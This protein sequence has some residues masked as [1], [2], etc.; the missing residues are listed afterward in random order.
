MVL[1]V[2]ELL[3]YKLEF[4]PVF[5]YWKIF[6]IR[7]SYFLLYKII[8]FIYEIY[9]VYTIIL[10]IKFIQVLQVGCTYIL[11]ILADLLQSQNGSA[12]M[13]QIVSLSRNLLPFILYAT[14]QR[15]TE[16]SSSAAAI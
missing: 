6:E 1:Q 2:V 12:I 9:T 8:R 11:G 14:K 7:Q 13:E 5:P 4:F 15:D 10:T 16:I 3:G